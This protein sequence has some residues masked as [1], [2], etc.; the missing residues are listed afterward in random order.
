MM[1][2]KRFTYPFRYT[3]HP[4]IEDAAMRLIE[5]IDASPE[6]HSL[7]GEG[8]MMGVLMVTS[9]D[10]A[11]SEDDVR[12]LYAFSGSVCGRSMVD[13]FVPPIF[14]LLDES[15]GYKAREAE[16]TAI[17]LRLS[18]GELSSEESAALRS[19]RKEKSESL[20]SWIF[21][22]YLVS[23][24]LGRTQSIAEVFAEKGLVPPG[25][26]GDC[27]APKLLQYAYLHH[28]KPLAMGEFWYGASPSK[29]V[30]RQGCF[31]PSCTGKCGP[32][33]GF[34]MEGL[35]VEPNPLDSDAEWSFE[36]PEIVFQD[37]CLVIADKPSGMLCVPGR[38]ARKS[39]QEWVSDKI[40]AQV[41]ACHRLD[42]DTCGLVILAKTHESLAFIRGQ[43]EARKVCKAYTARLVSGGTLARHGFVKLPL[44][45]D[46][47][48]RPRQMV[49]YENGKMAVTEYEVIRDLPSGETDIRFI[50]HTGRTHQLRV[51]SAHCDGL[52]RPIKGDRLYGGGDGLLHLRADSISFEHP[53]SHKMVTIEARK[54]LF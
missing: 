43:F 51:H 4:L 11:V 31:Y 22:R 1:I 13:G 19:L 52:G 29:E 15:N 38:S 24:A 35:D 20:Q 30:R 23:N 3:P 10:K 53:V 45:P 50:P 41:T 46:Y 47:Y 49:D 9:K 28:L 44:S 14:D 54:K 26:T 17:N 8:K 32:L 37:D 40:G 12:F 6:L 2:P 42:M 16:I 33:L 5:R 27:A 7:F 34:M 48:D 18:S 21:D 39:L 25:G 36:D